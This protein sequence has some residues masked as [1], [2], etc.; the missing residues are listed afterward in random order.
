MDHRNDKYPTQHIGNT[1]MVVM[2]E[3]APEDEE[4]FNRWYDEEHLWERLEIPGY[5]SARRFKL[6]E[7]NGMLNFLCIWELE[8]SS[9]LY[10]PEKKAQEARMTEL[11]QRANQIIKQRARGVYRQIFPVAGGAFEDHSG[12]HPERAGQ[13]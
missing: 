8:D 1:I 3:V 11:H 6:E 10:S 9:P 4:D 12:W 5:I 2:M 13:G 7:G